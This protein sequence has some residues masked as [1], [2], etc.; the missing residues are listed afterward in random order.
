MCEP[1]KKKKKKRLREK[2]VRETHES[3][4]NK[5]EKYLAE[6]DCM[7]IRSQKIVLEIKLLV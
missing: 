2:K 3:K 1:K 5:N 7:T 6:G 4:I